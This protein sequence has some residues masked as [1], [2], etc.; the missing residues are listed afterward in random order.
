MCQAWLLRPPFGRRL[1][2]RGKVNL[3][4]QALPRTDARCSRQMNMDYSFCEA[5]ARSGVSDIKRILLM[6]D[7][8]CQY[9]IHLR[10]RVDES[11]YLSIPDGIELLQGVGVWHIN[12]HQPECYNRFF[13]G[14]IKGIG[15]IVGEV[16][17]TLWSQLNLVSRST[18]GM[19]AAH[20]QEVLDDHMNDSNWKK[21]I[22]I[23]MFN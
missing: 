15:H 12:G 18:R 20:R 14:F 1:P 3:F 6:Y 23:G 4:I 9:G 22:N 10:R 11:K 17:E 19:S 13:P 7:V 8:V 21:L 5:I 2:K 16:V